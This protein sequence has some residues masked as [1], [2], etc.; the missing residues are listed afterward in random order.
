MIQERMCKGEMSV[1][2]GLLSIGVT[3][4]VL[5]ALHATPQAALRTYACLMGHPI[6][7]LTSPITDYTSRKAHT[8]HSPPLGMG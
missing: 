2:K 8:G 4:L 6:A 3:C 5:L 1:K 7:A